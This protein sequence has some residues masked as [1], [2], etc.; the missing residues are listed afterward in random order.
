MGL[1]A[2]VGIRRVAALGVTARVQRHALASVQQFHAVL[3]EAHVEALLHQRDRGR[4]VVA[5][6]RHVVVDVDFG[7]Q[8]AGELVALFGQRLQRR[9]LDGRVQFPP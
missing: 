7:A 1:G 3:A 9:Q 5:V 8:P 4:V 6:D 2:V